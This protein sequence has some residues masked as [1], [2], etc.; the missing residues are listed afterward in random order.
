MILSLILTLSN[1]LSAQAI[2]LP[3]VADVSA[4][5]GRDERSFV[6]NNSNNNIAEISKSIALIVSKDIVDKK[7]LFSNINGIL[8]SDPDGVNLCLN[9]KYAGHHTVN[10]C[11]GFMIGDNLLASAGHCFASVNDC[12]NKLII[13]NTRVNTE[14]KSGYKV[15]NRDIYECDEIVKSVFDPDTF[16]DFSIIKLKKKV[17]GI[18][19]LKL[20]N[21]G[22]ISTND[23][24]FMIGHPMGLPLVATANSFINDISNPHYFKATLDSFEGNSGSPVINSKTLE[25]E[26]ILVRGE[27]DFLQD[28]KEQCYRNVVY[29]QGS[30]AMP[31]LKGEGVSR[32]NDLL[33]FIKN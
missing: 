33:P 28:E 6:S 19:P 11:T 7:L 14:N 4:I 13:F 21:K 31:S 29:E 32:I 30:K 12:D 25:V 20:R 27:E 16:Q 1:F 5:Y 26:G 24:V 3:S 18:K 10:A 2:A 15:S 9:E 22:L 17:Y 8:L 23:Q